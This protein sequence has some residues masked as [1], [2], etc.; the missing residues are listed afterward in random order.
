MESKRIAL[1][2]FTCRVFNCLHGE[3]PFGVFDANNWGFPWEIIWHDH[4]FPSLFCHITYNLYSRLAFADQQIKEIPAIVYRKLAV[5]LSIQSALDNDWRMVGD[6]A[7]QL[8]QED[9]DSI[10][11]EYPQ[12]PMKGVLRRMRER[13]MTIGQLVQILC[14]MQRWDV[15]ELLTNAG[16]PEEHVPASSKEGEVLRPML[17]THALVLKHVR[18]R[19]WVGVAARAL[20]MGN[21][22]AHRRWSRN[23]RCKI[24]IKRLA[25]H[26]VVYCDSPHVQSVRSCPGLLAATQ[27]TILGTYPPTPP[28]DRTQ[29]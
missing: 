20:R 7:L 23:M 4:V 21:T 27:G 14:E 2:R 19:G 6:Q 9:V 26:G 24:S 5:Q 12:C 16:Y 1:G 8:S 15:V 17:G 18:A 13:R 28:L 22:D 29:T 11:H 25:E 3:P 10:A